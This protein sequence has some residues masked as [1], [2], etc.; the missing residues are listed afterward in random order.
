MAEVAAEIVAEE[1]E[2]LHKAK[3]EKA[4]AGAEREAAAAAA[5]AAVITSDGEFAEVVGAVGDGGGDLLD[6]S[7][8]VREESTVEKSAMATLAAREQAEVF[9]AQTKTKKKNGKKKR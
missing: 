2:F 1:K 6:G 7:P 4:Q 5:A 8:L 9:Q 3:M